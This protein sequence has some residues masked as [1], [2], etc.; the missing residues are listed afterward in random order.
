MT[1][2]LT[3][4][5]SGYTHQ[6]WCIYEYK[7]R[8]NHSDK[9]S[10]K[11]KYT[12]KSRQNNFGSEKWGQQHWDVLMSDLKGVKMMHITAR[13]SPDSVVIVDWTFGYYFIISCPFL[14]NN[15][16]TVEFVC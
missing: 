5:L 3:H 10:M 4:A 15:L 16:Q 11:V 12:W 8:I 1:Q 6:H 7:V 14:F 2:K 13:I 9:V